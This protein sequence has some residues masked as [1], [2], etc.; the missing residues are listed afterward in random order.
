MSLRYLRQFGGPMVEGHYEP[1][2]DTVPAM[3]QP[4]EYIIRRDKAMKHERAVQFFKH[5]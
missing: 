2:I 3:L 1:G 5:H 4:G